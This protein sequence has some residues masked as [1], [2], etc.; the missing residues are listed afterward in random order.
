MSKVCKPEAAEMM[1]LVSFNVNCPTADEGGLGVKVP[2]GTRVVISTQGAPNALGGA[3]L[4]PVRITYS[5]LSMALV[6]SFAVI[7][8][9]TDA[10]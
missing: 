2:G 9:V 7:S 4:P 3:G 5:N 8:N 1:E 10:I 6:A